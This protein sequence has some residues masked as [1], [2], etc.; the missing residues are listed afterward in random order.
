MFIF[1]LQASPLLLSLA[2]SSSSSSTSMETVGG[3]GDGEGNKVDSSFSSMDPS[4]LSLETELVSLVKGKA[5]HW[6][7]EQMCLAAMLMLIVPG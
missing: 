6:R 7:H 4:Y 1:F 2:S 5:L 3:G